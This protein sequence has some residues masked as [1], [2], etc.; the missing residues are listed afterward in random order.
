MQGSANFLNKC[1]W[2]KGNEKRKDRDYDKRKKVGKA[3]VLLGKRLKEKKD[4][5]ENNERNIHRNIE[6]K[7]GCWLI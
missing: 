5:K 4:S 3:I 1:S 6:R 7:K 2:A